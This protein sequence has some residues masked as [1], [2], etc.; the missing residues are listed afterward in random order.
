MFREAYSLIKIDGDTL[1]I[2]KTNLTHSDIT[3]YT[4]LYSENDCDKVK[5]NTVYAISESSMYKI[6][7]R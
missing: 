5:P 3:S 7:G 4:V 2:V 1:R 6:F